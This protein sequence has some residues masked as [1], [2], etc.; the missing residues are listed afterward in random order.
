MVVQS[1]WCPYISGALHCI[2]KDVAF[3]WLVGISYRV[4]YHRDAIPAHKAK[5]G[6]MGNEL[7][8]VHGEIYIEDNN[9][10]AGERP[11][12]NDLNKEDHNWAKY[13][14]VSLCAGCNFKALHLMRC[15]ACGTLC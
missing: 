12:T 11:I 4:I 9:I 1:Q 10:R 5:S 14:R 7:V 3:R 13:G 2:D 6:L 15:P 8:H